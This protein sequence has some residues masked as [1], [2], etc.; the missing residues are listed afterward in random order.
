[1]SKVKGFTVIDLMI[2]LSLVSIVLGFSVPSFTTMADKA[3]LRNATTQVVHSVAVA[4]EYAIIN[5]SYTSICPT[6]DGI[7]CVKK[8]NRRFMVYEDLNGNGK[9]EGNETKV[10]F[11]YDVSNKWNVAWKAFGRKSQITFTPEG[12]TAHQ[13]GSFTICPANKI[14]LGR[15]VIVNKPGRARIGADDDGDGFSEKANGTKMSC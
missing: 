3:S 14:E 2:T 11:I 6:E 12:F 5:N 7:S 13:N 15:T 10:V 9:Q 8:W 4:R 1:M